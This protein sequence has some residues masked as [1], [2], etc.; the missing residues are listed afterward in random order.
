MT[1]VANRLNA[2]HASTALESM[3]LALQS[4]HQRPVTWILD[5]CLKRLFTGIE[6]IGSFLNEYIDQFRVVLFRTLD[7]IGGVCNI[8]RF[9][10]YLR[11]I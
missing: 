5:P 4:L 7:L 1:Q 2:R 6:N 3:Q 11:R 9:D 10:A 8:G